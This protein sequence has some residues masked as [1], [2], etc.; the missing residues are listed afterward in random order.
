[1]LW[2]EATGDRIAGAVGDAAL[3]VCAIRHRFR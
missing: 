1:M 2:A 3:V